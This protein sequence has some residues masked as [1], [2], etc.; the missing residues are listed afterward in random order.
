MFVFKKSKK[1]KE[2]GTQVDFALQI[3]YNTSVY[4]VFYFMLSVFSV[5]W[6]GKSTLMLF[7]NAVL[8]FLN[9]YMFQNHLKSKD[10]HLRNPSMGVRWHYDTYWMLWR[11]MNQ[12]KM[13]SKSLKNNGGGALNLPTVR[14]KSRHIAQKAEELYLNKH[15]HFCKD[16]KKLIT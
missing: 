11:C 5:K 6:G 16:V 13:W 2:N 4:S 10:D 12:Q 14:K 9:T 1:V 7:S 3:Q 8:L 15:L